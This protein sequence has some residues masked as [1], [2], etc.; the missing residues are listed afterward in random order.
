MKVEFFPA[1][2]QELIE[3]S[4]HYEAQLKDWATISCWRW[5]GSR[6]YSSSFLL[7]ARSSTQSIV[8]FLCNGSPTHSSSAVMRTS[9]ALWPLRIVGAS[10]GTGRREFKTVNKCLMPTRGN[11]RAEQAWRWH[12][13]HK[14]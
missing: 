3:A 13:K 10:H 14:S 1:A 9:F 8:G 6:L 2:E 7:S 12:Q 11:P 5:S 4:E